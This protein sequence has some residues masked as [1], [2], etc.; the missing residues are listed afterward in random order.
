MGQLEQFV[1]FDAA[2]AGFDLGEGGAADIKTLQLA[3]GGKLLLS[4]F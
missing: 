3:L 4:E 1:I 2:Q